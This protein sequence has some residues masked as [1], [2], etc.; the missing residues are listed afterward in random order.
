MKELC[1][2]GLRVRE[3]EVV[4]KLLVVYTKLFAFYSKMTHKKSEYFG[5]TAV[6]DRIGTYE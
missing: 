5:V 3:A 6:E 2:F 4:L 1:T